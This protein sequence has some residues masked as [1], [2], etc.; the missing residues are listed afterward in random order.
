MLRRTI[1]VF[2]FW[3]SRMCVFVILL[4]L[5][6]CHTLCVC[7]ISY[8]YVIYESYY[9]YVIFFLYFIY[10]CHIWVILCV[11]HIFPLFYICMSYISH[12]AYMSYFFFILCMYVIY[13]SYCVCVSYFPFTCKC[14][15]YTYR[16]TLR[17]CH[18][19]SGFYICVSYMSRIVHM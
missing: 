14:M 7:F 13:K 5:K 15:S 18:I 4:T 10:V 12:T 11:C 3:I 8:M 1:L 19:F 17:V 16:V 6:R 2:N 9:V